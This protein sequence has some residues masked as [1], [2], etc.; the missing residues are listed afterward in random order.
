MI[1]K[2]GMGMDLVLLE[3]QNHRSK[4]KVTRPKKIIL[5]H[6][7][8]SPSIVG[9]GQRSHWSRSHRFRSIF[10]INT[11]N[12]WWPALFEHLQVSLITAHLNIMLHFFFSFNLLQSSSNGSCNV[13]MLCGVYIICWSWCNQIV[14]QGVI[15]Y[16][17][18]TYSHGK[19]QVS[20]ACFFMDYLALTEESLN[21]LWKFSGNPAWIQPLCLTW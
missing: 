10:S 12:I 9:Q 8:K 1:T 13:C 16:S 7:V 17:V 14:S 20:P 11:A 4:A 6:F 21:P 18:S 2:F 19:S 15:M 3:G 5:E